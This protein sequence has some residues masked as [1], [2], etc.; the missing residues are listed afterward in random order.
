MVSHG[1]RS[2]FVH[3]QLVKAASNVRAVLCCDAED[4]EEVALIDFF[5]PTAE[6]K[7]GKI[8]CSPDCRDSTCDYPDC[9]GLAAPESTR[10]TLHQDANLPSEQADG[11]KDRAAQAKDDALSLPS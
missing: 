9:V 10:C 7:Q 5:T 2:T 11:A 1:N 3:Q 6:G 8:F 4:C